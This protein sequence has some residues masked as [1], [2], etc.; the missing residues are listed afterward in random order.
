[1][2]RLALQLA[3]GCGLLTASVAEESVSENS[4]ARPSQVRPSSLLWPTLEELTATRDRPLFAIGR[5]SAPLTLPTRTIEE[6]QQAS[7]ARPDFTLKGII[8]E[9]S[10]TFVLLDDTNLGESVVI[11]SGDKI[12]AWRITVDTNRSVTLADDEEKITLRLFEDDTAK[13]K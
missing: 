3:L 2:K 9:G 6:P 7:K 4:A 10:S 8:V 12:G 13:S 1:M 5:R 11:R